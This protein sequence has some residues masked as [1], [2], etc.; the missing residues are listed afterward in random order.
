MK[1]SVIPE[2]LSAD[3][4]AKLLGVSRATVYG[5]ASARD[6]GQLVDAPA[7]YRIG[8]RRVRWARADVMK[9][10]AEQRRS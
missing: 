1:M 9:W 6:A 10:L 7:H 8:E 3:D 5:W 4:V 2:L